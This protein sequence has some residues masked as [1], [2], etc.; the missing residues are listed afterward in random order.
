MLTAIDSQLSRPSFL[1]M[2]GEGRNELGTSLLPLTI[3]PD[4][5]STYRFPYTT[6]LAPISALWYICALF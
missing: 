2:T 6:Y 3:P 1:G 4:N 5:S